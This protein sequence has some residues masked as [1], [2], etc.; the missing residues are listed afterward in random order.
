MVR[1]VGCTDGDILFCKIIGAGLVEDRLDAVTSSWE[2]SEPM[3]I[4]LMEVM[5][6]KNMKTHAASFNRRHFGIRNSSL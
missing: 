2:E 6:S 3:S 1:N 4:G 5:M